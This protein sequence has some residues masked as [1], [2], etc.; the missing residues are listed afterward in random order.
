MD[1]ATALRA[2]RDCRAALTR[3]QAQTL[4]GQI[5]SGQAEDAMRGLAKIIEREVVK[6]A[7]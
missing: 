3:Q 7:I 5:L 2:L 6:H 1:K 4:R